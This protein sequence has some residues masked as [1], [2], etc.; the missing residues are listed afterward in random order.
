LNK[1][2]PPST[3]TPLTSTKIIQIELGINITR[4][5]QICTANLVLRSISWQP[6][7]CSGHCRRGKDWKFQNYPKPPPLLPPKNPSSIE[8]SIEKNSSYYYNYGITFF[9]VVESTG[10]Q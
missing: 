10:S 4:G 2:P 1:P 6:I 7:D 9:F 5:T 3:C 8:S